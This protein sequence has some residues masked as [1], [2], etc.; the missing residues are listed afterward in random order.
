M[1]H[2]QRA[3]VNF[4]IIGTGISENYKIILESL[5]APEHCKYLNCEN[6][7]NA[8]YEAFVKVANLIKVYIETTEIMIQTN[9]N[10]ITLPQNFIENMSN[11]KI[12]KNML[13]N[14]SGNN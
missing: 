10:S 9:Q 6:S 14:G 8:I 7:S 2:P 11:L 4:V 1:A 3:N 13:T 12:N 5:C